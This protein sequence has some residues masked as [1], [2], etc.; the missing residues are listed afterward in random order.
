LGSKI[1]HGAASKNL[2][3]DDSAWPEITTIALAAENKGRQS[4][5]NF[6]TLALLG[7]RPGDFRPLGCPLMGDAGKFLATVFFT[8]ICVVFVIF[9]LKVTGV[10]FP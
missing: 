6:G 10:R 1:L 4:N 5:G 3:G 7:S 9:L 2:A 8:A